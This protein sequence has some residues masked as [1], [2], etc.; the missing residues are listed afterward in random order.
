MCYDAYKSICMCYMYVLY[1]CAVFVYRYARRE[2]GIMIT[3]RPAIFRKYAA[4]WLA[5]DVICL[6][7]YDVII[8]IVS[9]LV[10]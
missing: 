10:V 5:L 2:S 6:I 4:H 1:V 8:A 7:P 3:S 9:R